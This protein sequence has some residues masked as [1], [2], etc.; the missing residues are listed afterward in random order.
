MRT[1]DGTC[2]RTNACQQRRGAKGDGGASETSGIEEQRPESAEQP[3]VPGHVR[4]ALA[5]T[6]QNDQLLLEQEILRDHRSHAT[7]ATEL[8]GHDGQVQQGEQ[9][10]P[11]ARVSV[12]RTSAAA[13]RC[14]ILDSA[15]EL[16]IRDPHALSSTNSLTERL[17]AVAADCRTRFAERVSRRSSFSVRVIVGMLLPLLKSSRCARHCHDTRSRRTEQLPRRRRHGPERVVI[18]IRRHDLAW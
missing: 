14:S 10:I 18:G 12:G 3:V 1:A 15:R 7:G 8:R 16:A 9:D 5:A 6:A 13:Q 2:G 11:H 17:P 4:R